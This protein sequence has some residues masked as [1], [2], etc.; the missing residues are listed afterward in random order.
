MNDSSLAMQ[1]QGDA[2]DQQPH[3]A[4]PTAGQLLRGM[5]EDAGVH[6]AA[7][8][9]TL[10][11]AVE[12]LEA[13]EADDYG[14]F[15]DKVFMRALAAGA[16]RALKRDPA[17]VLALLPGAGPAAL[18]MDSGINA[19]FRDRSPRGSFSGGNESPRSRL[20]VAAVAVLL[21]GALGIALWPA[22]FSLASLWPGRDAPQTAQPADAATVA[23]PVA[24]AVEAAPPAGSEGPAAASAA[25]TA[26]VV[27]PVVPAPAA[28]PAP[29]TP[30]PMP[31]AGEAPAPTPAPAPAETA[32]TTAAPAAV[33][34]LRATAPS[35]V[36]VRSGGAVVLQKILA[37][38]ETTPVP[39]S[40]PWSVV[41]GKADVTQVVVRGQRFDLAPVTRENV[42][43]F[44]VK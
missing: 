21:I 28:A 25:A 35:W 15:S 23:E 11:V 42:A 1:P 36:Q 17:P 24:S 18:R 37:A 8:A 44:E 16:C 43:R 2:A 29:A 5:R 26:T 40:P 6:I 30:A 32:V 41:I 20:L 9:M 22:D 38:G 4:G 27:E 34:E 19:T 33:L 39:G 14:A 10:K 13:L 7:L 31:A 3:A 12:R